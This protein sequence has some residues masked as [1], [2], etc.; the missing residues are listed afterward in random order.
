MSLYPGPPWGVW[1]GLAMVMDNGLSPYLMFQAV[2][3]LCIAEI[4]LLLTSYLWE[5]EVYAEA[6]HWPSGKLGLFS[7][8]RELEVYSAPA[9]GLLISSQRSSRCPDMSALSLP[10]SFF[11]THSF[12]YFCVGSR[13]EGGTRKMEGAVVGGWLVEPVLFL[14]YE[15]RTSGCQAWQGSPFPVEPPH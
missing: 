7:S 10:I 13:R 15:C 6:Q 3:F 11:K 2:L 9:S 5:A 14:L 8:S 12:I 4:L 1:D